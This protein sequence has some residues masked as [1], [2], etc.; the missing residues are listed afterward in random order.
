MF[1]AS[2]VGVT[3]T[4]ILPKAGINSLIGSN[5]EIIFLISA[6]LRLIIMLVYVRSFKEVRKVKSAET[7]VLFLKLVA[8]RPLSGI[9][10]N[11]MGSLDFTYNQVKKH[12]R[13]PYD[14]TSEQ[15]K[16]HYLKPYEFTS[17]QLQKPYWFVK[18]NVNFD[19]LLKKK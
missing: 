16:K 12:Y 1:I 5:Y 6:L 9:V 7:H 15:L 3:L 8:V 18:N 19:E 11:T 14:F 2:M 4:Y 13:K 10:V 17:K